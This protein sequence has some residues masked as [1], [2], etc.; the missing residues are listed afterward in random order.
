MAYFTSSY[1]GYEGFDA[2][3]AWVS[4]ILGAGITMVEEDKTQVNAGS[5]GEGIDTATQHT[6][7]GFNFA[8]EFDYFVIKTGEGCLGGN[9]H[10]LYTNLDSLY[11]G[12]IDL[13]VL[14]VDIENI[15]KVSHIDGVGG[16]APVPEPATLMLLGSGLLGLAGFRKKI[17]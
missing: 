15:S 7:W 11:W 12:V 4:S 2:E 16:A 6:V 1:N 9:N 10:F 8:E 5:W 13:S 14:G 3:V 17:K